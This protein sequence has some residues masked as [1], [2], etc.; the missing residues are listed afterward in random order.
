MGDWTKGE[1]TWL[2]GPWTDGKSLTRFSSRAE[3]SG[4]VP[5]VDGDVIG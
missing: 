5:K 2:Q 4:T 1:K 3:K